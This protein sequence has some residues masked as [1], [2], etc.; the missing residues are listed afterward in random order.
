M[1]QGASGVVPRLAG[2]PKTHFCSVSP[3]AGRGDPRLCDTLVAATPSHKKPWG[4]GSHRL[5]AGTYTRDGT[6]LTSARFG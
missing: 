6:M 3:I 5:L 2:S 1:A 4:S